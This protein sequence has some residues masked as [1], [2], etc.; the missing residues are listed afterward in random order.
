MTA[1]TFEYTLLASYWTVLVAELIG[2][3]SIYT[4]ASLSLRFRAGLV[5][6]GMLVAFGGKMLVAVLLGRVLVQVPAHWAAALSGFVFFLAAA[7]TWFRGPEEA[8]ELPPDSASWLRAT[9]IPFASLFLTEWGDPGQISAAALTAQSNQP[10]AAWIGGTLAMTTKGVLALTLGL[11]L[12]ERI[13][14]RALRVV[15]TVSCCV[16][17]VL[18]LGDAFFN[19]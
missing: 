7:F 9:L 17:G 19:H 14:R 18:A 3:K 10:A 16:L 1:G 5:F 6:C 13:N 8:K 2:D 12:R 4:V 11:R 15:A